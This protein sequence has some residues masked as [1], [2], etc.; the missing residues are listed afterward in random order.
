MQLSAVLRIS[1]PARL[2]HEGVGIGSVLDEEYGRVGMR[3]PDFSDE[4]LDALGD[5]LAVH[6]R[7]A[8]EDVNGRIEFNE[9]VRH[10]RFHPAVPGEAEINDGIIQPSSDDGSMDHASTRSAAA[11]GD[12]SAVKDNRFAVVWI[13][14]CF[15][16]RVIFRNANLNRCDAVVK[17]KIE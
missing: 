10:F 9:K 15:A 13:R 1:L 14:R 5:R 12:G 3:L 8:V 4:R 16:N 11:L 2:D 17:R 6:I 7:Q